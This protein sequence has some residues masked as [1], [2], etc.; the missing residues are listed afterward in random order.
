MNAAAV[1][2]EI[3]DIF[4]KSIV[5]NVLSFIKALWLAYWPYILI[6]LFCLI[7]G[8]ILQIIWFRIGSD[9]KMPSWFNVLAG[10]IFYWFFFYLVVATLYF[11]FGTQVIDGI[12]FVA[13]SYPIY[14]F[15]KIFLKWIGFWRY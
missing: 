11:I 6:L 4:I 1:A 2:L 7:I 3:Q 9:K 15:N 8:M 10:S 14:L 12:V 13:I 5:A